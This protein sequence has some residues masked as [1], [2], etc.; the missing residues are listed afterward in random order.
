MEEV[1]GTWRM[2]GS[3]FLIIY[4]HAGYYMDN[5]VNSLRMAVNT[6]IQIINTVLFL[7]K[8]LL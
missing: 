3:E 1:C 5:R 6:V 4:L 7:D 8:S 2:D